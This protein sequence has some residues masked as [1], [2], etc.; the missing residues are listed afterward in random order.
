MKK[1][2]N[3]HKKIIYTVCAAVFWIFVWHL[4]AAWYDMDFLLPSPW[5]TLKVLLEN[6]TQ[7]SFWSSVTFS[8]VRIILGFLLSGAFGILLA[9]L[10]IRFKVIK[11]LLDP[12]CSVLRAVP[13]ASFII[14]VLVMFS[15][16]NVAAIISFLMGFPLVYSSISKGIDVS[17][18]DLLEMSDVFGM[19]FFKKIRYIYIP[20]LLP[21]IV[22]ALSVSVGLCFKSGIAAEVIGYPTGSVGAQMYLAKIG[23]NM[24]LL[25]SYTAVMVI[26]SVLCEK[27]ISLILKKNKRSAEYEK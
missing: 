27:L 3:K 22:S 4:A 25:L 2:S 1:L 17:P 10:S 16:E 13:V 20:H 21:Y 5:T 24:P 8:V 19:S 12:F 7:L 23:F 26:I 11:I 15:S 18:S 14:L 9:L 6:I